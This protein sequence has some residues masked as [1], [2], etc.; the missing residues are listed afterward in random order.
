[1]EFDHLTKE[2]E[3]QTLEIEH[4]EKNIREFTVAIDVKKEEKAKALAQLEDMNANLKEKKEELEEIVSETRQEEEKLRDDAK[5][6]EKLIED[7]LLQAFK[8]I[9]KNARNGLAVV[10]IQRDACGGCFNKIPPQRQLDIRLRKKII[11]CEHCGRI[12]VDSE[13]ANAE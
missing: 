7:R 5:Q 8:R 6:L 12:L 9:R 1:R 13:L 4:C 2:V 3:Y 11:V 10:Y